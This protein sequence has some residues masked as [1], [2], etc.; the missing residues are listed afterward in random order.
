[1][2]KH[3]KPAPSEIVERFKFHSRTRRP[4]E[5]VGVFVAELRSLAEFCNFRDTSDATRQDCLRD[6]R[7]R[8]TETAIREPALNYEK[9][10]ETAMNMETAAQ[11]MKELKGRADSSATHT[12]P[13]HQVHRTRCHSCVKHEFTGRVWT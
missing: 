8:N 5:S 6:Q 11:S 12:P 13:H 4:G 3:F 9:A 7:G 2:T 10:V 1:M